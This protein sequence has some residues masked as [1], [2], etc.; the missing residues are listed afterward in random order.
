[1]FIRDHVVFSAA[2][3]FAFSAAVLDGC[4]ANSPAAGTASSPNDASSGDSAAGNATDA[5]TSSAT[6]TSTTDATSEAAS[7][8]T[9]SSIN[10]AAGDATSDASAFGDVPVS[11]LTDAS[12]A[13]TDPNP[14]PCVGVNAAATCLEGYQDETGGLVTW[15]G[16]CLTDLASEPKGKCGVA[17]PNNTCVERKAPGNLDSTC[18]DIHWTEPAGAY[19]VTGMGQGCCMWRTGTCGVLAISPDYGC[20]PGDL[21]ALQVPCTPDFQAGVT[22]P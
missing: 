4:S 2:C 8:A 18:M 5:A 10:D 22:L 21:I 7:D 1:M 9:V 19:H 11:A 14:L 12:R 20:V 3:F 13:F 6:T 15:T 17:D 16:C